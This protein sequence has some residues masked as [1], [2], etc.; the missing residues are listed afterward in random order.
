VQ[1]RRRRERL[2]AS[3]S[4]R[5][6]MQGRVLG[7]GD[8]IGCSLPRSAPS[9]RRP[10]RMLLGGRSGRRHSGSPRQTLPAGRPD[11][12]QGAAAARKALRR[13]ER[14]N[15]EGVPLGGLEGG[16]RPPRPQGQVRRGRAPGP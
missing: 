6:Q 3:K 11:L 2:E 15:P 12:R 16:A 1:R 10:A 9:H 14:G 8:M 5:S 13:S 7:A 4:Q